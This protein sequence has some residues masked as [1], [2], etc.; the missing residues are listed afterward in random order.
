MSKILFGT[1]YVTPDE[2]CFS[3]KEVNLRTPDSKGIHRYMIVTVVRND[4]LAEHRR[5]L[6]PASAFTMEEFVVPGGMTDPINK[7]IYIEE[8]VGRLMQI[9]DELRAEV[10]GRPDPP[11]G[12]DLIG[13]YFDS[14]DKKIRNRKKQTTFGYGGIT[15]RS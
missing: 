3:L 10:H 13:G 2:P 15:Q 8:T 1:H 11:K 7:R 4:K 14:F 6:G 12:H 5:D 9:A